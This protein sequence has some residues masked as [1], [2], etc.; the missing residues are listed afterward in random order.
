MEDANKRSSPRFSLRLKGGEGGYHAEVAECGLVF[1]ELQDISSGGLR[2]K[3]ADKTIVG[4]PIRPGQEI[5]LRSFMSDKFDFVEG[6][7]GQVAWTIDSARQ[8][9]I[10]FKDALPKDEV[11]ALIF[12]FISIFS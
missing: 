7:T 4:M 6:K 11:E 5:E 9:G 8:F 12:H 2:G 10:R 3:L 1:C